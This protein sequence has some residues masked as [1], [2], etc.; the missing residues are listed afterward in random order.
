VTVYVVGAG[1]GDAG[2]V[3]R[4]AA[5]L[6]ARA[7]V[8]VHDRLVGTEVLD[9]AGP[10]ARLIDVGK[11]PGDRDTQGEINRLLVTLGACHETVVRL[12]GGDPFVFGRGAEEIQSLC[13]AGVDVEVVPGIS[14]AFAGPLLAGVP[15]THRGLATGV[16]VV[17]AT[18]EGGA[19]TDFTRLANPSLTLVVLMGVARR[20]TISR[21]L[22]AGGLHPATPVAVIER[23][24]T[25]TQRTVRCS[26]EALTTVEIESPAVIVIGE[27]AGFDLGL[28]SLPSGARTRT[29]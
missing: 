27:V 20:S 24:S 18:S 11:Y 1:P 28:V 4:R 15:V 25:D 17:T 26:L 14:S 22:M 8:V 10:D 23:A 7:D 6:L 12:K 3:T 5:A 29:A 13:A 21:E 9:L 2:L 19:A 16:T